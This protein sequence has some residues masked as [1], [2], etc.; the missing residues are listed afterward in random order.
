MQE[1]S[2]VMVVHDIGA[3]SPSSD[4]P[5]TTRSLPCINNVESSLQAPLSAD[6]EEVPPPRHRCHVG[7]NGIE[8]VPSQNLARCVPLVTV[9]SAAIEAAFAKRARSC[10]SLAT[11][12]ASTTTEAPLIQRGRSY[13]VTNAEVDA[14]SQVDVESVAVS[15]LWSSGQDDD[16][17]TSYTGTFSSGSGLLEDDMMTNYTIEGGYPSN[18]YCFGFADKLDERDVLCIGDDD[19]Y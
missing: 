16:S 15:S 9:G 18:V 4:S 13:I 11:R 5:T 14:E 3:P 7:T 8:L 12:I 10:L 2:P 1:I 19:G 6:A 17:E